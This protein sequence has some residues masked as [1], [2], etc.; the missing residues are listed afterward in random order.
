[1]HL[2]RFSN[3]N[4]INQWGEAFSLLSKGWGGRLELETFSFYPDVAFPPDSLVWIQTV[5]I[6]DPKSHV[7][8]DGEKRERM[9]EF[10]CQTPGSEFAVKNFSGCYL[11]WSIIHLSSRKYSR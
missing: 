6:R 4:F 5:L 11:D 10:R 1:M 2:E 3:S 8:F 9:R 7:I